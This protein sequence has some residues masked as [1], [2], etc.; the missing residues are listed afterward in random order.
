LLEMIEAPARGDATQS[1]ATNTVETTRNQMKSHDIKPAVA[2]R[3]T[4]VK[5][6]VAQTR[7]LAREK[8]PIASGEYQERVEIE[9]LKVL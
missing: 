2:L 4:V 5:T 9:L 7:K 1:E 8:L 3:T 6:A